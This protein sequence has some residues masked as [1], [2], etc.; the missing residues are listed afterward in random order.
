M[1]DIIREIEEKEI[2]IQGMRECYF[3]LRKLDLLK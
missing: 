1:N 2:F 3:L